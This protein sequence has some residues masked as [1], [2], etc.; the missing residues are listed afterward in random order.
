LIETEA[1]PLSGRFKGKIGRSFWTPHGQTFRVDVK[2]SDEA[3]SE[4]NIECEAY[5]QKA[6]W[7]QN[8]LMIEK[9]NTELDHILNG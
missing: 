6:D 1:N 9:F 2:K 5:H 3:S 8:S 4:I 7:G